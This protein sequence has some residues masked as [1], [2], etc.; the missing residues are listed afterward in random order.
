MKFQVYRQEGGCW[1]ISLFC[2][3]LGLTMNRGHLPSEE[4][5]TECFLPAHSS[6]DALSAISAKPCPEL[7]VMDV[8]LVR[9]M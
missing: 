7:G 4:L 6:R 8:A 5:E 1:G 2:D 3:S 9:G